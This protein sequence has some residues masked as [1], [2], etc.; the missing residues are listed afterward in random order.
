MCWNLWTQI[1]VCT[2]IHMPTGSSLDANEHT[3]NKLPSLTF[4]GRI[5][6]FERMKPIG[7]WLCLWYGWWFR[8]P[9]VYPIVKTGLSGGAGF[10]PSTVSHVFFEYL[11]PFYEILCF[12]VFGMLNQAVGDHMAPQS[13]AGSLDK[14][15]TPCTRP[16]FFSEICSKGIHWNMPWEIILSA[17]HIYILHMCFY[18]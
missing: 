17:T 2:Y 16:L 8:N 4:G 3:S 15:S 6:A 18:P 7:L 9:V 10:L 12:H 5:E 14:G 13:N 11:L 1:S